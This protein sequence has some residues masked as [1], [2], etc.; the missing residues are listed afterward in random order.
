MKLKDAHTHL[1]IIMNI[2]III[3]LLGVIGVGILSIFIPD[4]TLMDWKYFTYYPLLIGTT[5]TVILIPVRGILL[6]AIK[7]RSNQEN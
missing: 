1:T 7:K 2:M 3:F 5:G 6:I 4:V